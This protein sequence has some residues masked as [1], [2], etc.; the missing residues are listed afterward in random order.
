MV[1]CR[2]DEGGVELARPELDDAVDEGTLIAE[3]GFE[4]ECA[5]VEWV[6]EEWAGPGTN[7][8]TWS[9]ISYHD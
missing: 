3:E 8:V 6:D 4:E 7:T 2:V 5:V 9:Q 1:G